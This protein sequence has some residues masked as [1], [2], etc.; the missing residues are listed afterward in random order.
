[1]S[2]QCQRESSDLRERQLRA[3]MQAP[4]LACSFFAVRGDGTELFFVKKECTSE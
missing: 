3:Q 4:E 1:M 2:A